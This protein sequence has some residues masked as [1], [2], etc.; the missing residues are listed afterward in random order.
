VNVGSCSAPFDFTVM[1]TGDADLHIFSVASSNGS[2]PAPVAPLTIGPGGSAALSVQ[3][4]PASGGPH[5]GIITVN[6]DAINAP[7]SSV[8]VSGQ[9][10]TAPVLNAIG[11]KSA[12]AF[13]ELAFDVSAFD[14]EAD[15]LTY[16]ATPLPVGATFDTGSGHFSWT[17]GPADAGSYS[18]EFCADD[19]FAQDCETITITVAAANSPPVANP[20]GPYSGATGQPIRAPRIRTATI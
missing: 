7:S 6:S 8:N 19:G 10:N 5:A 11:D 14:A 9:G 18:V 12:N 1:N 13:V 17:P 2:F 15:E 20:G 4:C 3:F 16:S